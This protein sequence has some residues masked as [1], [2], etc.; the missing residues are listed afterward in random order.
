MSNGVVRWRNG[1]VAPTI[2]SLGQSKANPKIADSLN[3]VV[4]LAQAYYE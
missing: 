2:G 3:T 4:D 1:E